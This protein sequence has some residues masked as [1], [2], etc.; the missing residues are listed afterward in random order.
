MAADTVIVPFVGGP[1]TSTGLSEL[2]AVVAAAFFCGVPFHGQG[3]PPFHCTDFSVCLP[4]GTGPP[5]PGVAVR[6][7]RNGRAAFLVVSDGMRDTVGYTFDPAGGFQ[8]FQEQFRN[9]NTGDFVATV[10]TPR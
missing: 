8:E 9:H 6:Q 2:A 5:T 4:D 7:D 1:I 3:Q 10:Q